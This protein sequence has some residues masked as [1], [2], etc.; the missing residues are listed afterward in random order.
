MQT[1][2]SSAVSTAQPRFTLIARAMVRE[3]GVCLRCCQQPTTANLGD[4]PNGDWA[5]WACSRR[6]GLKYLHPTSLVRRYACS[7]YVV[8][9][10]TATQLKP[11]MGSRV[12]IAV[13]K[14]RVWLRLEEF[15]E[16]V[17]VD[18][19]PQAITVQSVTNPVRTAAVAHTHSVLHTQC[20]TERTAGK[21][22]LL[23]PAP[24]ARQHE[25]RMLPIAAVQQGALPRGAGRQ[26]AHLAGGHAGD[27][28]CR[29]GC[30]GSPAQTRRFGCGCVPHSAC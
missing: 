8:V 25:P 20:P 12:L 4:V 10:T 13:E 27:D 24:V 26:I 16:A 17:V 9:V 18:T 7:F 2:P 23:Q 1:P 3:H 30:H 14:P 6:L 11:A 5:C 29:G 22:G 19:D 28:G 15:Y 21:G